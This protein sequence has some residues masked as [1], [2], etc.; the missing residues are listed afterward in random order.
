MKN[1]FNE[2][3]KVLDESTLAIEINKKIEFSR[4]FWIAPAAKRIW[5][6]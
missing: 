5:N 3:K 2:I 1:N 6:H 4:N